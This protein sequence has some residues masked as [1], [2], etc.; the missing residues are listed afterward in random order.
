M[1]PCSLL[2]WK[3]DNGWQVVITCQYALVSF[4][5]KR[6]K[7]EP[8]G[9][10]H[11]KNVKRGWNKLTKSSEGWTTLEA[12]REKIRVSAIGVTTFVPFSSTSKHWRKYLYSGKRF[13]SQTNHF[14]PLQILS[15]RL[16]C[17]IFPEA[18]LPLIC[19][20][21]CGSPDSISFFSMPL[22]TMWVAPFGLLIWLW[23]LIC[24][25]DG[26]KWIWENQHRL[27]KS[28]P[29][30]WANQTHSPI[31]GSAKRL[32]LKKE[33]AFMEMSFSLSPSRIAQ[34]SLKS[35]CHSKSAW[36]QLNL[37]KVE[38]LDYP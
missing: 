13:Y 16:C 36:S 22:T 28:L 32:F 30:L 26:H 27:N 15:N 1:Q 4:D 7:K 34:V 37:R 25:N 20:I 14:R 35:V 19:Q 10:Q 38:G 29:T 8:K 24:D 23:W 11:S 5:G 6:N 12:K 33:D 2:T 9:E 3:C 18:I 31:F 21:S 17:P